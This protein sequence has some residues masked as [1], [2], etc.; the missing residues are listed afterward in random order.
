MEDSID[1]R[2]PRL[3]ELSIGVVGGVC[4]SSRNVVLLLPLPVSAMGKT[5]NDR[6]ALRSLLS[7]AF[8]SEVGWET[9]PKSWEG[10]PA[11]I[12]FGWVKTVQPSHAVSEPGEDGGDWVLSA[13]LSSASRFRFSR[14]TL[15]AN[16]TSLLWDE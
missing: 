4:E 6:P 1:T 11:A 2:R 10:V 9:S 15:M 13:W 12:A 14:E 8:C 16:I 5:A 3:C 7:R